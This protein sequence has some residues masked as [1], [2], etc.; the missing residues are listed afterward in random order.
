MARRNWTREEDLAVLYAKL[1]HGNAF[2]LHP[3]LRNLSL[4]M[5]RSTSSLLMRKQILMLRILPFPVVDSA[6]PLH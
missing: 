2:R 1:T 5:G 3:D 6:M 4:A